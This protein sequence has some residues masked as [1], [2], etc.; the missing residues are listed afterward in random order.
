[1]ARTDPNSGYLGNDQGA[2]K[3]PMA[4]YIVNLMSGRREFN[5]G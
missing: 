3:G 2:G 1:M 5:R 4:K